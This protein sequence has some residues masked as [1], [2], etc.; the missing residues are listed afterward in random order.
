M[1]PLKMYINMGIFHCYVSL[2]EGTWSSGQITIHE[3]H[4]STSLQPPKKEA[5]EVHRQLVQARRNDEDAQL[6]QAQDQEPRSFQFENHGKSTY[7]TPNVPP[8]PRNKALLRAYWPGGGKVDQP[9][10]QRKH[11]WVH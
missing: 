2:P 10:F 8:S 3:F 7:V 6:R 11:S 9:W 1:D 4:G 5:M